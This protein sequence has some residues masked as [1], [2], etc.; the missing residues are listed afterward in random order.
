[1]EGA[2]NE[3]SDF[4]PTPGKEDGEE[5]GEE[6]AEKEIGE[7]EERKMADESGANLI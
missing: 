4:E 3:G 7:D 2:E 5:E 6:G 1:M